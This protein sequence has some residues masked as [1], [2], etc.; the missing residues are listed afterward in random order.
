MI[1]WRL[2]LVTVIVALSCT[3]AVAQYSSREGADE[4]TDA[5]DA[6]VGFK[7]PSD[8]VHCQVEDW[9]GG[10]VYLR[11]DMSEI[12]GR[13][14]PRPRD[15]DLD[16]GGAFSVS[17]DKR[18]AQRICHGDTVRDERLQT[19]AYG[20]TWRKAGFTCVSERS[21]LTCSNRF[22]SGFRLSRSSQKI[23]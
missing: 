6:M 10:S 8:N 4:N 7:T 1:S 19:L 13:V 14:P 17:R 22:G 5:P 9:G 11:C 20:S 15:C 18:R 23:F 3:T 2:L 16:W 21:G 12:Q